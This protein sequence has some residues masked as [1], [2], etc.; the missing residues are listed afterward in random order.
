MTFTKFTHTLLKHCQA[1]QRP[2][3]ES[4]KREKGELSVHLCENFTPFRKDFSFGVDFIK[5]SKS[6]TQHGVKRA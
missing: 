1:S 5:S 2:I 6:E 4:V 3:M